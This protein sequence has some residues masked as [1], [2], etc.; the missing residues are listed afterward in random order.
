M[1]TKNEIAR[2]ALRLLVA[3]C[4]RLVRTCY[5]AGT[6]SIAIEELGHRESFDLDFHTRRALVDVRPLLGELQVQ[7]GDRFLLAQPPDEHGSGFS[8]VLR[9]PDGEQIAVEVLASFEEASDDDLV[10]SETA[11]RIAR[12]SLRRYLEDKVQCVVE[13]AEARD[14]LDIGAVLGRSP[15][16]ERVARRALAEQDAALL[17][18]RLLGWSDEAIEADLEAYP[19][20]DPGG[21]RQTRD[22]LL[23]WLKEEASRGATRE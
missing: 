7:F 13:R 17:A 21:A 1:R 2:D 20:A 11:P 18:E 14:L 22:R 23:S 3:R 6:S 10:Q 5:W 16:L 8:G 12:V 9:L 15:E 19:E 4:P